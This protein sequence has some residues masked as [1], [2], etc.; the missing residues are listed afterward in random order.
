MFLVYTHFGPRTKVGVAGPGQISGP[1]REN[2]CLRSRPAFAMIG[3]FESPERRAMK[4]IELI[5]DIDEQHRLHAQVPKDLPAGQIR[6]ILLPGEDAA[7]GIWAHGI[8]AEWSAELED[9]REEIYTLDDGQPV[10]A[11]R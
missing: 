11:P 3:S 9:P 5:G 8:A 2:R 6:L 7:G 1:G 4:T 10:N